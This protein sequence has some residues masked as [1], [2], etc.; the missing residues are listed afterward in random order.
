VKLTPALAES[1]ATVAEVKS[2][3]AGYVDEATSG[4]TVAGSIC[5]GR[6]IATA[7]WSKRIV[8][9]VAALAIASASRSSF[10]CVLTC[11]RRYS[12]DI[13]RT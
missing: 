11:G 13:N 9:R 10:F 8:G 2:A 4:C 12:G 6:S 5:I 3:A 1:C 7:P